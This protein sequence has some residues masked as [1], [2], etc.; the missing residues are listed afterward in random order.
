MSSNKISLILLLTMT[1]LHI[2]EKLN[3]R[4]FKDRNDKYYKQTP[5]A[6]KTYTFSLAVCICLLLFVI[7]YIIK[8]PRGIR[9]NPLAFTG[10]SNREQGT[11]PTLRTC[12][13][14]QTTQTKARE[15]GDIITG[16][17][18]GKT[19]C[20]YFLALKLNHKYPSWICK[21]IN[22]YNSYLS[23]KS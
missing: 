13:P 3:S 5:A 12:Q 7:F 18:R 6:R 11:V 17:L 22:V 23:T 20:K 15:K 16:R 14:K 4:F 21:C 8:M 19:I 10:H 9:L 2:S 1:Y